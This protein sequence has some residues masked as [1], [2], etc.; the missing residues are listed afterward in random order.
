MFKLAD[1]SGENGDVCADAVH[2]IEKMGHSAMR[3]RAHETRQECFECALLY[4]KEFNNCDA[5][6]TTLMGMA[7]NQ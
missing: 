5:V 2:A 4:A 1:S 3:E 6:L 7:E